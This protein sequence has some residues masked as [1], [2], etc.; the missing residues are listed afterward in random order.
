MERQTVVI[1]FGLVLFYIIVFALSFY[2][3]KSVFPAIATI[4]LSSICCFISIYFASRLNPPSYFLSFSSLLIT[5][6]A[7]IAM[8]AIVFLEHGIYETKYVV[9]KQ[10]HTIKI[11]EE[12]ITKDIRAIYFSTVTWTT[13]GYGDIKPGEK[14]QI[15]AATEAVTGLI[16]MGLFVGIFI[17]Y[18]RND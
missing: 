5:A 10:N 6:A 1:I 7:V 9:N 15:F 4:I 12:K 17:S 11:S 16:H 2:F 13:L 18:L 3:I 14:S 8:Y